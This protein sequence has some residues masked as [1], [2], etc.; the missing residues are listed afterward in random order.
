MCVCGWVGGGDSNHQREKEPDGGLLAGRGL[1]YE[2]EGRPLI[3]NQPTNLNQHGWGYS[4]VL[5]ETL[6]AEEKKVRIVFPISHCCN[7]STQNVHRPS[8]RGRACVTYPFLSVPG[9]M[10]ALG[11]IKALA[12]KFH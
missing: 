10:T 9:E 12:Q 7:R 3:G 5:R 1:H 11:I 4:V 8:Q 2:N 6:L